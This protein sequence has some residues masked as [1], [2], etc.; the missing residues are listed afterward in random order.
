[1]YFRPLSGFYFSK[2]ASDNLKR[3]VVCDFRPLSGF[4]FSKSEKIEIIKAC[5]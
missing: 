2:Y 4:Y 5:V 1:M 3:V